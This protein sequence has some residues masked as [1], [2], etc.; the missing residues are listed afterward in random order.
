MRTDL[1]REAMSHSGPDDTESNTPIG[2][3]DGGSG[4]TPADDDACF[5]VLDPVYFQAR[6]VLGPVESNALLYV[7]EGMGVRARSRSEHCYWIE[8]TVPTES[9]DVFHTEDADFFVDVDALHR[10]V[11]RTRADRVALR[12]KPDGSVVLEE[13]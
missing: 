7:R 10:A 8:G 4:P 2:R 9:F 5:L 1:N 13:G 6:G 12:G 11:D 3:R